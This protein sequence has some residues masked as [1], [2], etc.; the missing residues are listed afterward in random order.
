MNLVKKF[1]S[2]N[3]YTDIL[4]GNQHYR[5]FIATLVLALI[6]SIS[7]IYFI[8]KDAYPLVQNLESKVLALVEEVYPEELEVKINKGIVS[9]NVTEPY[10][11]TIREETLENLFSLKQTDKNTRSRVR[12]LAIDTKGKAD[13][14]ER[15]QSLALLTESSVVYYND[16]NVNIY[17]LREIQDLTVNKEIVKSKI[18]EINK[19][20][21]VG[22]IINIGV[23]ISPL[24]IILGIFSSQLFM[25]LLLTLAVYLMV[26]IN[27]LQI[28][29]KNTF[30]YSAS[31]AFIVTLFWNLLLFIPFLAKNVL[32]ARS[33]LTIIILGLAYNGI[34]YLKTH[35][36]GIVR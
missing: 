21:I 19:D 10:Y 18:K 33:V 17:P 23:L 25:F 4:S 13:D 20:N 30:R 15:Y 11:I 2:L 26:K 14:F 16:N 34:Y 24:F 6:L 27:Q 5:V 1:F 9:T 32:V 12:L 22:N 35:K 3:F 8:F 7:P 29:F 28:G 31:I 36:E